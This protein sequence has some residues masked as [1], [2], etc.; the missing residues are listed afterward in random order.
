M[1]RHRMKCSVMNVMRKKAAKSP[2]QICTGSDLLA[3]SSSDIS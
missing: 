1:M 2:V 3:P